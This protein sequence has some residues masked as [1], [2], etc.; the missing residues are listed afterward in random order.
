MCAIDG[1][2]NHQI[3]LGIFE[4]DAYSYCD[5]LNWAARLSLPQIMFCNDGILLKYVLLLVYVGIL[6]K[7]ARARVL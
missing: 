5:S 7:Y 4:K 6:L 1:E 3:W 2:H